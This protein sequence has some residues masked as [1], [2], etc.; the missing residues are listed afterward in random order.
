[1]ADLSPCVTCP[2]R[3]FLRFPGEYAGVYC[4][5]DDNLMDVDDN[6]MDVDD[7]LMDVDWSWKDVDE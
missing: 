7:D 2:V 5:G 6:L 4:R 3:A 1:M